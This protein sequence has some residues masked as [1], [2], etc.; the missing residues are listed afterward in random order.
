LANTPG[1]KPDYVSQTEALIK[2]NQ[3]YEDELQVRG[4]GWLVEHALVLARQLD[5]ALERE[6]KWSEDWREQ[7]IPA[8]LRGAETGKLSA[9]EQASLVSD[10]PSGN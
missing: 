7:Y 3:A 5:V 8:H 4:L 9:A 6:K 10:Q 2:E 1:K